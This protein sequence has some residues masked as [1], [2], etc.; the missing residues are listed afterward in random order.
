MHTFAYTC[1]IQY[2]FIQYSLQK[3]YMY[4]NVYNCNNYAIKY[5]A[6]IDFKLKSNLN[7]TKTIFICKVRHTV[8][9]IHGRA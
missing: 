6:K 7:D 8:Q 9:D 1:F 4:R 5:F 3:L 2:S